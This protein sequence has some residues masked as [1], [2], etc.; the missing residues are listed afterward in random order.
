[1]RRI[2]FASILVCLISGVTF[3][4]GLS[5]ALDTD[6]IFE[7]GGDEDWFS[8]TRM[9]YFDDDAAE[10]GDIWDGQV[11]WMQTTVNGMG[12]LGF[13]WRVSSEQ[14]YDHLEF[15]IDGVLQ[16][17]ISGTV[18]WHQMI[19]TITEP[20]PHTLEWRYT[21]DSSTSNGNDLGRVDL[22][23]W[24]GGIQPPSGSLSEALDT[25][26]IFTTD[27]DLGWFAQTAITYFDDDAVQ[28][29]DIL[30]DQ[31]SL[32]RT[33][34]NGAGTLN[35]FWKVSSEVGYDFLEFFIDGVLQDQI[36]GLV[37][38]HQMMY[39]ISDSGSHVLEWRYVKDYSVSGGD[40]S[41]WI[42]LVEWSNGPQPPSDPLSEALDTSLSFTTDGDADWFS[43]TTIT[44]F[45]GDAAQS[46]E[47][48]DE[49]E[50]LIQT[51]VDG[52]G[53]LS[54]FW[55]VSSEISYDYLEFFIDGVLQDR[56]SGSVDWEQ[57]SYTITDPGLHVLDW[58]YIKDKGVSSGSDS[59][60]IDQVQWSG[61]TQPPSDD[62][63]SQALDTGLSFTTAGEADWFDQTAVAYFD[64]DAAQSGDVLDNQESLIQTTVGGAGT[65]S[66]YWKVS[67]EGEY[68]FLEFYIDGVL[69]DRISGSVDWH[70]MVYTITDSS[71]HILEWRYFK[72]YSVSEGDDSGWIDLVEWSGGSPLPP[73]GPLSEALDTNLIFETDGDAEWFSQ[74]NMAYFGDDAVESGGISHE[75]SSVIQTTVS[76]A[77]TFSFYWKVSSEENY[78]FLEFYIDGILQD[79][80]SGDEDWHQM[81]YTISESGLH[82]LEWRYIKDWSES[83]GHDSGWLDFVE[84]SGGT[85]PPSGGS[86]SEALDTSMSLST[87]GDADWFNQSTTFYIDSD[88]AQSGIISH[89]QESWMQTTVSISGT[90]GFYWK[91]S[92][93]A[94]YD[95]LEFYIDGS[96]QDSISGSTDWQQVL[97]ALPSGTYELKWRYVKDWSVSEGDDAGWVDA[98]N[99]N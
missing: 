91:V 23:D 51:I 79:R 27:G 14:N 66:F 1:M 18:D 25:N 64:G 39:T 31:S 44:Y 49:Q 57:M 87:G 99:I 81:V 47:I 76:G 30:D 59:G 21:K 85:Q 98:L 90:I 16:N 72:D 35:F 7:T 94:G 48:L 34:V 54:F 61:G 93:E 69:Q 40:D 15:Y 43:Q 97:Y 19:Y 74:I 9:T 4:N 75:Q 6:L 86:L 84:W 46:G 28:S 68:D 78:D 58:R 95:V 65:F 56:I 83:V 10:S 29:G 33:T 60:W 42:D 96:L 2:L 20:G 36:S 26:L 12:T 38:W 3:A 22:V 24:S 82:A 11:S 63:L 5:E 92:S 45:D 17:R 80:I 37:D 55:K 62:P 50:S 88:A 89:N 32:M 77:G 13:Y 53:T 52:A 8:Q 67:S 73:V 41:G 70:Q 71:S